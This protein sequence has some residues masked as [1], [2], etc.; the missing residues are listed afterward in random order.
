MSDKKPSER[1][2]EIF[3]E[4]TRDIPSLKGLSYP[5]AIIRYLDEQHANEEVK[6]E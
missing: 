2:E 3:E 5:D 1:I 4:I 6:S